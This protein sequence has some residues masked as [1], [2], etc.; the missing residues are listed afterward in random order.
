MTSQFSEMMSSFTDAVYWLCFVFLVNLSYWPNFHVNIITGSGV[1]TIFFYKG[2]TRNLENGNTP[3]EFCPISGDWGELGVPNLARTSPIKCY[4]IL[5]SARVTPFTVSE[6][7]RKNQQ[8][9]KLLPSPPRLGLIGIVSKDFYSWRHG[10]V[11]IRYQTK[12]YTVIF[13]SGHLEQYP[14]IKSKVRQSVRWLEHI[15]CLLISNAFR[16][17]TFWKYDFEIIEIWFVVLVK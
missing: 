5:Q 13:K 16:V 15:P 17:I 2:L 7:L 9:V 11:A 1:V 4:W 6:L 8:G 12:M 3:F 10:H 14:K